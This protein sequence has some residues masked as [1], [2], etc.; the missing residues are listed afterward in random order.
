MIGRAYRLAQILSVDIV[1]GAVIL[2]RFFCTRSGVSPGWQVYALLGATVWLIYTIDHL[3]DAEKSTS[4]ARERYVFHKKHKRVLMWAAGFVLAGIFSLLFFIP[5]VIFLGGLVLG[6][7]SFV[8]LLVQHKLSVLCSK[9]L[10]VAVVYS[11]GVLM[12]PGLLGMVF[13]WSYF[14]LLFFLT[15]INL[16]IFSWYEREEDENDNFESIATRMRSGVLERLILILLACGLA[17]AVQ[18]VTVTHL[19]FFT[20]FTV[21]GFMVLFPGKLTRGHWYRTIGDGVFLVPILFEWL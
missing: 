5:V 9:E 10:Y 4:S 20:G 18:K 8:Y 6:S 21:Y 12:V 17:L 14:I 2:L 7:L 16:I 1:I 11:L 15:Y 3:R 13:H 19:Y